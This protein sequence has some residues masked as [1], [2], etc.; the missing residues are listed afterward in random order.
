MINPKYAF[1]DTGKS[2]SYKVSAAQEYL[3]RVRQHNSKDSSKQS[4]IH[5]SDSSLKDSST[6]HKSSGLQQNSHSSVFPPKFKMQPT[7]NHIGSAQNDCENIHKDQ[8]SRKLGT[9][10]HQT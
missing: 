8:F 4:Y 5:L 2:Y 10:S 9:V 3:N 7:A 6:N 1:G